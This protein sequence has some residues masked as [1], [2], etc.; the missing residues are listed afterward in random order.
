V[1][2]K[3]AILGE[4]RDDAEQREDDDDAATEHG[5][6]KKYIA[7]ITASVQTAQ[8]LMRIQTVLRRRRVWAA[9]EPLRSSRNG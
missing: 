8:L 2:L 7:A 9:V 3:E 5:Q 4:K 6:L 1:H